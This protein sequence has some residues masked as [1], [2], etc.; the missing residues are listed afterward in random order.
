M[1][2]PARSAGPALSY[3][4]ADTPK[5][6]TSAGSGG[7]YRSK[8]SWWSL[9]CGFMSYSRGPVILVDHAAEHLPAPHRCI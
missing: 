6:P 7:L 5:A 2:T 9:T 1:T 3:V 8:M 4:A